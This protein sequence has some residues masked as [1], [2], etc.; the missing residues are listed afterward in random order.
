[1]FKNIL[2]LIAIISLGYHLYWKEKPIQNRPL[3]HNQYSSFISLL[4]I[5][6]G[7]FGIIL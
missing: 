3:L 2:L 4:G 5:I 6:C 7:V 1:M